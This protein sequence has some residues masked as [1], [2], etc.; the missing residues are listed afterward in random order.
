MAHRHLK[1]FMPT[2]FYE[3]ISFKAEPIFRKFEN[4]G[5]SL[6]ILVLNTAALMV[7]I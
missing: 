5:Q 3:L 4:I 7:R 1:K 2:I 6:F